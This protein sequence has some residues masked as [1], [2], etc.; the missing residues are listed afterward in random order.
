MNEAMVGVVVGAAV[1][2]IGQVLSYVAYLL[3]ERR[4]KKKRAGEVLA[5]LRHEVESHR[6]TYQHHLQWVQESVRKGGEERTGYSYQKV[7]T[8]AYDSVFLT[9]WHLVPKELLTPIITYY[10][11]V[12]TFNVLAGS[13]STPTPVPIREAKMAIERALSGAEELLGLLDQHGDS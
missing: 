11:Q 13:F 6:T 12:E 1:A 2:L 7:K 5:L 4:E 8:N 9:Y 10:T 3:K